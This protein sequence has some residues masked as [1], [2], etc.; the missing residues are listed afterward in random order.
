MVLD[1]MPS[2]HWQDSPGWEVEKSLNIQ[3]SLMSKPSMIPERRRNED[4]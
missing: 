3:N 2:G 1:V 4:N